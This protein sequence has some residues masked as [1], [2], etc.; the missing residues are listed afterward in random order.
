MTFRPSVPCAIE[1]GATKFTLAF[2]KLQQNAPKILSIAVLESYM[3]KITYPSDVRRNN[4]SSACKSFYNAHRSTLVQRWHEDI[5]HIT[6][7]IGKKMLWYGFGR[8]RPAFSCKVPIDLRNIHKVSNNLLA[9]SS[10]MVC[11]SDYADP[12]LEFVCVQIDTWANYRDVLMAAI[13]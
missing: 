8:T 5:V 2:K 1:N 12:K 4:L 7:K 13:S 9:L 6:I 10:G 3:W 11:S